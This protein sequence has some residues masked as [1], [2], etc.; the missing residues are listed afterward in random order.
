MVA[1]SP[2]PAQ[3]QTEDGSL[4]LRARTHGETY[5]SRHGAR[6]ESLHV[7]IDAAGLAHRLA[8]GQVSILEIG[9]GTGLN[10]AL[11]LDLL[12][13]DHGSLHYVGFEPD[14]PPVSARA[15]VLAAGGVT[16]Q[17]AD[18]VL[19]LAN[20]GRL[21]DTGL[22]LL[23]RTE[24][25]PAPLNSRFDVIWHDAFSPANAPELWTP[26]LLAAEFTLLRPGGVWVSYCA[27]GA[28]RRAL[29]DAGFIVER[30]PG[31]PG[32]R[33]MLRATRPL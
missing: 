11:A 19:Q 26:D 1:Q 5:H 33:E 23:L 21:T 3:V 17:S 12:A 25:F 14:L 8:S 20:H 18:R 24:P 16:P 4:T 6:Q 22:D 13:P 32:K 2:T 31:P 9:F 10:L 30:L 29:Q 27:R 15:S 7:F 28:V